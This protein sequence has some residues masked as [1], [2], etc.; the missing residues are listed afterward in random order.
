MEGETILIHGVPDPLFYQHLR[1][2]SSRL[3]VIVTEGRP[4]LEGAKIVCPK[5]INLD[6]ET[7]LI[8]DNMMAYCMWKGMVDEACLFYHRVNSKGARCKIGSLIMGICAKVHN[9]PV[10]LYPSGVKIEACGEKE[11]IFYFN[12]VRI[13]PSGIEAYVPLLEVIP[14]DYITKLYAKGK[15]EAA[16][17]EAKVVVYEQ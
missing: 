5:L 3:S 16:F 8:S 11:D 4:Y 10:Y 9:I 7:T 14:W 12:G 6:I 1:E 15:L 2:G 13:A 17:P